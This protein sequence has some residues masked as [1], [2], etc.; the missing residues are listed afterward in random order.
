VR[1]LLTAGRNRTARGIVLLYERPV[2]DTMPTRRS[3]LTRQQLRQIW[4]RSRTRGVRD[5]LWE[6]HRLRA[7]ALRS[8]QLQTRL[9]EA[10][11]F[12]RFDP[13]TKLIVDGLAEALREEPAVFESEA[14]RQE[15]MR[16]TGK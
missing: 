5:L 16:R 11:L 15:L 7:I 10:G 13:T 1:T 12:S 9:L 6:I 8:H 2:N 3:P 14:A 4:E